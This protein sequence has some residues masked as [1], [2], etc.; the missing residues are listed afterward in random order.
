[1]ANIV[2]WLYTNVQAAIQLTKEEEVSQKFF[3]KNCIDIVDSGISYK[4]S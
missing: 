1:M 4:Y 3:S 2:L